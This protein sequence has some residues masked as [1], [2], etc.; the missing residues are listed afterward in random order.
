MPKGVTVNGNSVGG[1]SVQSAVEALRK[2]T[3]ED[4]KGKQLK[5]I[6][7][8][9]Q[10]VFSYPEISYKDDFRAVLSSARKN[11]TYTASVKY[12]LCGMDEIIDAVCREEK[13]E[14]IEPYAKFNTSG[15]PFTYF[16]GNDGKQVD[17]SRLKAD[18]TQSLKGGFEPINI[19]YLTSF[20]Q[21]D[22][23]SVRQ[24]TTLLG[25]F[26]TYFDA[27]NT[28]R[29][30]NIRL[31]S[32][33]L[34]GTVVEGGKTLSFNDTVGARLP[35]R[36]FRT[37]K[38]IENGEYAEGV[39]GGV[40]QV[41][42]TLYNAALLSGMAVTEYHPHSLSVGYVEPSRDAMVSGSSCDL[43]FKNPSATPVYIRS[44]TKGGSVTFE[45]YGKSDG[46]TYSLQSSVTSIVPAEEELCTDPSLV[47]E[48]KDG[49]VSEGYLIINRAGFVKKIKLRTDRYAPQKRIKLAPA[50]AEQEK[51][52]SAEPAEPAPAA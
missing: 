28:N 41:S 43:K 44:A 15:E 26:T 7:A 30:S 16:E 21:T 35:E 31:A 32:A 49:I 22:L 8:K 6:G 33:L 38:I 19:K 25:K 52:P 9:K 46:A 11:R 37:A 39:G 2:K 51:E 1:L 13:V 50:S 45:L 14:K 27:A 12:Y 40:C 24:N 3:E 4:L 10:Y 42:T 36:G 47:K 23:S 17:F 20:R 18:I 5:I 48:G 34:N 29:A